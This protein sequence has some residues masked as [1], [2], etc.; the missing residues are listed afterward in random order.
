MSAAAVCVCSYTHSLHLSHPRHAHHTSRPSSHMRALPRLRP[1]PPPRVSARRGSRDCA[2]GC[3]FEAGCVLSFDQKLSRCPPKFLQALLLPPPP[4][5]T[6]RPLLMTRRARPAHKASSPSLSAR[7]A[8]RSRSWVLSRLPAFLGS[9]SGGKRATRFVLPHTFLFGHPCDAF[10]RSHCL[11][12]HHH[13][14]RRL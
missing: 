4:K 10:S 2:A 1:P 11:L 7:A 12:V 9:L 6:P 5:T 3:V 14:P 13:C 8:K